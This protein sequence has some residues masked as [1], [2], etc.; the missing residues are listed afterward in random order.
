VV[1]ALAGTVERQG[2]GG[3]VYDIR[4]Y[5]CRVTGGT[6]RPGDDAAAVRWV[7]PAELAG[8]ALT[9]GLLDAL[10]GWGTLPS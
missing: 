9:D 6:L 10:R 8:L 4:D 7:H 2:P 3:V 5:V 1:G